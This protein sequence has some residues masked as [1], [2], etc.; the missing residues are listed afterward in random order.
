M[1]ALCRVSLTIRI[2]G[3]IAPLANLLSFAG[4]PETFQNSLRLM[5]SVHIKTAPTI[6]ADH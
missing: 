1:R 3:R 2:S 4:T 5:I 6:C